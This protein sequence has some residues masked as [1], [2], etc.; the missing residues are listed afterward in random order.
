MHIARILKNQNIINVEDEECIRNA[1]Q[2]ATPR[3]IDREKAFLDEV[4]LNYA[5]RTTTTSAEKPCRCFLFQNRP[6]KRRQKIATR[7][8]GCR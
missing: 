5:D 3:F 7:T 8:S 6:D 2:A 1:N 4:A